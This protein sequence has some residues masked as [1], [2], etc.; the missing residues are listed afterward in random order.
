M[1]I[2]AKFQAAEEASTVAYRNRLIYEEAKFGTAEAKH[3]Q[4]SEFSLSKHKTDRT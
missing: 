3:V 2:I 4:V 1:S